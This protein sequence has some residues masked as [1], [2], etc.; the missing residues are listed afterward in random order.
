MN[1]INL[2]CIKT[3]RHADGRVWLEGEEYELQAREV[4]ALKDELGAEF[5]KHFTE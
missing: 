5:G 2:K 4:K 3:Y 1:T